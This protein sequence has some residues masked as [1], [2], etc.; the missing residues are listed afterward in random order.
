MKL[1]VTGGARYIWSHMMKYAQENGHHVVVLDDFST[2]HEWATD[3]RE[4]VRVNL[5]DQKKLFRPLK[6][7][8]F[9]GVIHF[10]AKSIVGESLKKPEILSK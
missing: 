8:H 2:G 4:V 3:G 10:A 5:L 9:N 1:L 6:N 7:R